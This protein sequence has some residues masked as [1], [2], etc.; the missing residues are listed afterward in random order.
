[1]SQSKRHGMGW[2]R[3]LPDFRDY[4]SETGA[5]KSILAKSKP[6]KGLAK[7]LSPATDLRQWC[8][9]IEDQGN[10]GSCTAN[11]GVGL[12]EYYQRRAFGDHLDAARLFLYKVT[13]KLDGDVGDTGAYLRTTMKA[14]VLFGA[15]PE[16]YWPYDIAAFDDDPPAFCYS[17]ALSYRT[18]QFYRLDP[19]GTTPA[20]L[21]EAIRTKLAVGLPSM[22]GFTVYSSIPG[23]GAGN[24]DIPY[25]APGDAVEGGHAIVAV[26]YDDKRKIGADKGA[27][28]IRN[29]WGTDW[30][31]A[32]YGWLPYRYVTDGLA[33]DFW[34]LVQAHSWIRSCSHRRATHESPLPRRAKDLVVRRSAPMEGRA[35]VRSG[36]PRPRRIFDAWSRV[37]TQTVP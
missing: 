31:E 6:L 24:G 36:R 37:K 11:A 23:V 14:M 15:P 17:F 25:P 33:V 27:F 10:L 32:G 5:V 35:K 21:L 19:S 22:F 20:A 7:A 12:L 8:S 1:M 9:P 29:S 13:R 34:S 18:I 16:R 3:D 30:G 28:L 26:G 2:R 4:T